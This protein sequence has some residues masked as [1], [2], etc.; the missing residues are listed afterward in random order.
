MT[1]FARQ[2]DAA[3][4]DALDA[5]S[6]IVTAVAD[7]VLPAVATIRWS[8]SAKVRRGRAPAPSAGSGSAVAPS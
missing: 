8:G 7:R 4:I 3:E 6:R 2:S 1:A 5:Y